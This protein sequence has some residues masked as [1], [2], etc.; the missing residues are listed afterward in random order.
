M[1]AAFHDWWMSHRFEFFA[2]GAVLGLFV[3]FLI[4]VFIAEL[5][6]SRPR[7]PRK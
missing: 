4:V 6:A 3:L 7:K 1:S 2:S 5:I